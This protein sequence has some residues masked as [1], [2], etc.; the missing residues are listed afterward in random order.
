M[1]HDLY[2]RAHIVVP[3]DEGEQACPM[4][5][6]AHDRSLIIPASSRLCPPCHT[7]TDILTIRERYRIDAN[8]AQADCC[9]GDVEAVGGRIDRV[10]GDRRIRAAAVPKVRPRPPG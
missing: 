8:P 2:L 10:L 5:S 7:R 6:I 4:E 9:A 3:S 1:I